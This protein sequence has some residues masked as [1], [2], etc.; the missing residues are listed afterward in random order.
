VAT[1]LLNPLRDYLVGQGIVRKPATPAPGGNPDLPPLWLEPRNGVPAPGES[2]NTNA[3][4]VGPRVVV[5][6]FESTGIAPD[7]HEGFVRDQHV[8]FRVRAKFAPDALAIKEQI[9]QYLNDRRSWD[10]A[11]LHVEESLMFRDWQRL[12]SDD[13]SF[14]WT[15]EFSF[16]LWGPPAVPETF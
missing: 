13:Q 7:R 4:E 3:I 2:P 1:D 14:D 9:R 6:A 5:G 8:D 15:A 16:T 11:G 12:G 10:M